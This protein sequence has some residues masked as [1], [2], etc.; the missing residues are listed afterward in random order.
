MCLPS[1]SFSPISGGGSASLLVASLPLVLQQASFYL[2]DMCQTSGSLL[3][4]YW[5]KTSRKDI[6]YLSSSS[7]EIVF[8]FFLAL[9]DS[10]FCA[11]AECLLVRTLLLLSPLPASFPVSSRFPTSRCD[12]GCRTKAKLV[13]EE[14]P[15][16]NPV[17]HP[18]G[19]R[20]P[21]NQIR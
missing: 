9:T 7:S 18:A 8:Y 5:V 2:V 6:C 13:L 3:A 12:E 17:Q 10:D 21:P 14:L 16:G 4:P 15:G 11:P 20:E 1:L 19:S